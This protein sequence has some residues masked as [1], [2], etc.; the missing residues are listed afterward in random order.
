MSTVA[1][2]IPGRVRRHFGLP[3]IDPPAPAPSSGNGISTF[4]AAGGGLLIQ[5]SFDF[6]QTGF[7][8]DIDPGESEESP[9]RDLPLEPLKPLREGFTRNPKEGQELICPNCKVELCTADNDQKR[10][11][12]AVKAC[13]HVYCGECVGRPGKTASTSRRD[14][15]KSKVVRSKSPLHKCVVPGCDALTKTAKNVFQVYL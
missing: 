12:W 1:R 8:L 14:K 6:A 15:G 11:I 5:P 2:T 4:S 3:Q 13:G 9:S 7:D 10:Q